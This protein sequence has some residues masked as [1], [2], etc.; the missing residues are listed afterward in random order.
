MVPPLLDPD[1]AA[2]ERT[3][4]LTTPILFLEPY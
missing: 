1:A 2:I 4:V 3:L